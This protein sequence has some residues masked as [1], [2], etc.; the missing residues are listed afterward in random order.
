MSD[1]CKCTNEGCK[2]KTHCRRQTVE[3]HPYYQA[4]C[5]FEPEEDGTCTWLIPDEEKEK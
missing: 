3:S 4:Y 2:L 5:D 1:I